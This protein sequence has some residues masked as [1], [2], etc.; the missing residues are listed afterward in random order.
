MSHFS[1]SNI[2]LKINTGGRG[3]EGGTEE[4]RK[5]GEHDGVYE[6]GAAGDS[7]VRAA[8]HAVAVA[9]ARS[10]TGG[11]AYHPECVCVCVLCVC[12]CVCV[13][14]CVCVCCACV[15]VCV[16]M[17][18]CVCFCVCWRTLL[19]YRIRTAL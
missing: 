13:C 12:L 19:L 10:A 16:D 1:V 3:G 11:C 14:V 8:R 4:D 15:C 7:F 6:G 17:C 2:Q 5:E 18:M 9:A